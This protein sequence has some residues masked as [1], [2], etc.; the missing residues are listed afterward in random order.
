M[1]KSKNMKP[2]AINQEILLIAETG[3]STKRFC[4][5]E[6]S[7]NKKEYTPLEELEKACWSGLL[8]EMLPELID[9]SSGK[10]ENFIWEVAA[11]KSFVCIRIGAYPGSVEKET[12][13]DPYFFLERKLFT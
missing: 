3:L 6:N 5:K 2:Q 12:S 13:L 9:N 1:K 11:A 4:E 10:K 7:G 8:L